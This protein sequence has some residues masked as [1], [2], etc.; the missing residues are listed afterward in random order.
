MEETPEKAVEDIRKR[1]GYHAI[2]AASILGDRKMAQD[3]CETV[4]MPGAMY[5]SAACASNLK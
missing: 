4:M 1:L 3:G 2:C 5:Q